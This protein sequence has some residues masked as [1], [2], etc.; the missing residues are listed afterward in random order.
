[1]YNF[2]FLGEINNSNVIVIYHNEKSNVYNNI[3]MPI[4]NYYAEELKSKYPER[5]IN[6]I[7]LALRYPSPDSNDMMFGKFFDSPSCASI[8]FNRFKGIF[9]IDCSAYKKAD[10]PEF[11]DLMQFIEDSNDQDFK[12][13][14]LINSDAKASFAKLHENYPSFDLEIDESFV[15]QE[16]SSLD[17]KSSKYIIA[18]YKSNEEFR[19]ISIP[20]LQKCINKITKD[21]SNAKGIIASAISSKDTNERR[22][23]F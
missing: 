18:E 5:H 4:S 11:D 17:N 14:L 15:K 2:N 23:G 20:Q 1:M 19:R 16:A 3:V 10:G 7:F 22:I 21:A 8:M 9:A 6:E 13:I 12:F